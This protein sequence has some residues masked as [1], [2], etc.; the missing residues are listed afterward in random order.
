MLGS[1][2]EFPTHVKAFRLY[3]KPSLLL[4]IITI[5]GIVVG[6]SLLLYSIRSSAENALISMIY[7]IIVLG[8][9]AASNPALTIFCG[10]WIF[11][12]YD[13]FLLPPLL[14][15]HSESTIDLLHPL[16]LVI[17]S[18]FT[19]VLSGQVRKHAIEKGIYQRSDQLRATLLT[20]ISHNLRTPIATTKTAISSV[21]A[22]ETL[23]AEGKELLTYADRQCDY[24]NRL[25]ENV[26]QLSRLE[27]KTLKVNKD[28]NAPDEVISVVVKRWVTA[29]EEGRLKVDIDPSLSLLYFDFNIIES[30]IVNFVE[31]GFRHGK[32]PVHISVVNKGTEAWF[33]VEDCG[34]GVPETNRQQLFKG[35]FNPKP[36]GLGLGLI[37]CRGLIEAHEGR[38]WAEFEPTRFI[39]SIPIIDEMD[40][41]P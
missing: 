36:R 34:A 31:N 37:A 20:L 6:L 24:L 15:F 29:F 1:L 30:I 41:E 32:P 12:C 16:A 19:G 33:S 4:Q 5:G 8:C 21:L 3:L 39:F 17:V 23:D 18:V 10:I 26:L 25:I 28:W 7:L 14:S 13:F 9:S 35:A 22:L 2:R 40:V 38:I 11:L 27:A